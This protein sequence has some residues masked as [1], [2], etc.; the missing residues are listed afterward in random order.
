MHPQMVSELAKRAA[1][2]C[3]YAC[4]LMNTRDEEILRVTWVFRG[5]IY[6]MG[7]EV[8]PV[9]LHVILARSQSVVLLHLDGVCFL[10]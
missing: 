5:S 8:V 3:R 4:G 7:S 10:Y 9:M 2:P 1:E 6:G